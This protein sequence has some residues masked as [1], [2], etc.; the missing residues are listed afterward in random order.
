MLT[1]LLLLVRALLIPL[2]PGRL[3]KADKREAGIRGAGI[4][5]ASLLRVTRCDPGL[6]RCPPTN[7]MRAETAACKAGN[8]QPQAPRQAA[9]VGR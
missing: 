4:T 1:I 6:D 3:M 9:G 2:Q 7:G 8:C 5:R